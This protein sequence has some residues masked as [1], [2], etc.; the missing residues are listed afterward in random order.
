[1]RLWCLRLKILLAE[2][3][4]HTKTIWDVHF[5]PSG[6]YFL[7]GSADGL[8]ILWRTDTAFSQRIFDHGSDIYKVSFA[9][10]PN[11]AISAGEDCKIK[12]WH[13]VEA[14]IKYVNIQLFSVF[15]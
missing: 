15:N 9:K 5:N 14:Q 7:S 10:N 13:I 8:M 6:Y 4:N 2:Y 3:R 11:Y 1:V 12:I